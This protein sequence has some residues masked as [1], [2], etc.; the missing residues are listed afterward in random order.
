MFSW[1]HVL[2]CAGRSV[3]GRVTST[4]GGAGRLLA[5]S[6]L[7]V[8]YAENRALVEAMR[9]H[10]DDDWLLVAGDVAETVADIAGR[11]RP[12]RG[13]FRRSLGA[14]QPRAVDPPDGPV[15]CAAT[16]ATGTW[17]S[18][19]ASSGVHDPRGP[20]PGLGGRRRPG[21]RRAAVPA[22]RLLASGRAG[23]ATKEEGAG[24]TRDGDRRRLHRRVPAAPRPLPEPR[25]LVPGPG[26]RD[27]ARGSPRCPTDLPTVLVNHYPLHRH[28]TGVLRH[29]EFAMWCGTDADR[30]LAPPLPRR[31]R[32]STA[33]CT[34]RG[35]TWHDG[36][37]FEE[38]SLGYPREWRAPAADRPG[39]CAA[40]LPAEVGTG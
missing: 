7:H 21:R 8:G 18:S 34:S 39:A 35:T 3:G 13:R 12:L 5:I 20:L 11:W 33:T 29:P 30:R 31:R 10:T 28:P 16:P 4:A 23:C 1:S 17:S 2:V 6:D 37:R 27:R 40:I 26:R 32:S 15:S 25:G 36:V 22:L 38:V 24:A 14:R 9:P 19:A